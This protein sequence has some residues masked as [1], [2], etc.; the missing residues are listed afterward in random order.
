MRLISARGEG[1]LPTGFTRR[2]FLNAGVALLAS[3]ALADRTISLSLPLSAADDRFLEEIERVTFQYF[4]ECSHPAT[5]LVKDRNH[6]AGEDDRIVA[7][8]AATGFGLSALCIADKR[9]W[10]PHPEARDRV[11]T[12]LRFF[13]EQMPQERGFFYHFIDWR[14]GDRHWNCE[15]S[16]IDTALLLGGVLTCRAHFQDR[17]IRRLASKICDRVDW[18]W[19][20]NGGDML[21]HGWMPEKGFLKNRW[22]K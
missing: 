21:A 10:L 1:T 22:S 17:D 7:S 2:E 9:R 14:N 4:R 6:A 3:T 20:L 18:A 13:A 19:M 16:S 8:I 12:T 11:Q 5:G 15:L